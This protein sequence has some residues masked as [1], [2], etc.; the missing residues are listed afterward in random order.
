MT[1]S[2]TDRGRDTHPAWI[3]AAGTGGDIRG[4]SMTRSKEA[5]LEE[6]ARE[7][8]RITELE[9]ALAEARARSER[10]RSELETAL[11]TPPV[12][13]PLPS[14]GSGKTSQ[15][16]ADKVKL[17]RS[18]FRGRSDIFPT[19]FVSKRT[20]KPGYAPKASGESIRELRPVS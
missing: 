11:G 9:H 19:R 16:P 6:S 18:L 15:T 12:V 2:R 4:T 10:L 3:L 7:E 13:L 14:A 5:I 1:R 17:F 20:G 8:Q